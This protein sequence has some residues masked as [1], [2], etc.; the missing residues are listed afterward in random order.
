M[1]GTLATI[2]ALVIGANVSAQGVPKTS[3]LRVQIVDSAGTSALPG[4]FVSVLGANRSSGADQLGRAQVDSIPAGSYA[5]EVFHPLL[6]TLGIR[7]TVP[8]RQFAAGDTVNLA[9]SLPTQRA[10]SRL[11]CP[12]FRSEDEGALTG[13]VTEAN[14]VDVVADATVTATWLETSIGKDVGIRNSRVIRNAKTG[15]DGRFVVCNVPTQV[16]GQIVAT[17][18]NRA[19]TPVPLVVTGAHFSVQS[20]AFQERGDTAVS[21]PGARGINTGRVGRASISGIVLGPDSRPVAGAAVAISGGLTSTQTDSAGRFT[22]GGA[23]SGTQT[24]QVRKI[25]YEG[26]ERAVTLFPEQTRQVAVT[27]E[28][29]VPVLANVTVRAVRDEMMDKIGFNKRKDAGFGY[30]V[31]P[32]E[33]DRRNPIRASDLLR[34]IPLLQV[35]YINNKA[36]VS[37][38]GVGSDR[39]CLIYVIDG[40][41]WRENLDD[42]LMPQQ[43]G[44]IEVYSSQR[45]PSDVPGAYNGQSCD[46]A[47]I[48]TKAKLLNGIK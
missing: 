25:G 22:L 4:A 35:T 29:F 47:V 30:F 20:L 33:I 7:L 5:V 45:L 1:K 16:A 37:G 9:I 39:N 15:A 27:M 34:E 23:P 44:A 3:T 48:W 24:L 43:V 14:G 38:R 13:F 40:V 42:F 41:Q 8:A 21:I 10:V 28:T 46:M 26:F 31:T 17:Q 36:Q 6:D 11:K 12:D 32:E 2:A 18:G 19:T